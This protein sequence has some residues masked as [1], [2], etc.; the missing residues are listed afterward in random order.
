MIFIR[1]P[2]PFI[3][4]NETFINTQI[5]KV[6]AFGNLMINQTVSGITVTGNNT[7]NTNSTNST[8][9][10]TS[11]TTSTVGNPNNETVVVINN[12]NVTFD[13]SFELP[14]P[15]GPNMTI[16]LPWTYVPFTTNINNC[17]VLSFDGMVWS[18]QQ[19]CTM[20]SR[21][22]QT[23]AVLSCNTFGTFGVRCASPPVFTN[24]TN[25]TVQSINS[26]GP[27]IQNLNSKV[28]NALTISNTGVNTSSGASSIA[29]SMMMIAI[30]GLLF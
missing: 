4:L 26:T 30:F 17:N 14:Y 1:N 5:I 29:Y 6:F 24:S 3:G 28:S 16:F 11:N 21:T 8:A 2:R 25:S 27:L 12:T 15:N 10:T 19:Q 9:I 20:D 13:I 7:N 22:D 18:P 23:Q